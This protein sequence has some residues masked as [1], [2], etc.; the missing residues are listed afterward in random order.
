M[1]IIFFYLNVEYK[2]YIYILYI[3]LIQRKFSK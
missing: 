3:I 2:N 1:T